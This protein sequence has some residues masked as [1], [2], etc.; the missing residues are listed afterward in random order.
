MS[1]FETME[2]L[3]WLALA[4]PYILCPVRQDS[5]YPPDQE[6]ACGPPP[7]FPGTSS[8]PRFTGDE[9]RAEKG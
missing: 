7:P 1:E 5:V 9:E 4:N 6:A 2:P 3:A 8:W